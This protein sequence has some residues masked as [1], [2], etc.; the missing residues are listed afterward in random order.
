MGEVAGGV[1]FVIAIIFGFMAFVSILFLDL[2][3][4]ISFGILG[5]LFFI[6]ACLAWG[7]SEGTKISQ[8]SFT[9]IATDNRKVL[10]KTATYGSQTSSLTEADFQDG[11]SRFTWR[12]MEEL[13]GKLFE[14][15]GYEVTVTQSTGDF[16]IDVEAKNSTEFLG[17]QVK[18]WNQDVGF[19]DCAKTIGVSNKYN[20]AIIISTKSGFTPQSWTFQQENSYRLELWNTDRFKKE[21]RENLID[22]TDQITFDQQIE[23]DDKIVQSLKND[24]ID[25]FDFD[26]GFN[27]DEVY[28]E[29]DDSLKEGKKCPKCGAPAF[30]NV[31]GNCGKEL[32]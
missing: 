7:Y 14:K 27:I 10:P 21:L 25:S 18:H 15:K 31:C 4:V 19:E 3:W 30:S 6:G 17:I 29:P 5:F 32:S 28:D 23:K 20:K 11:F 13:T 2:G 24:K 9:N 12:H 16:G 22:F 26:K 1:L 8:E